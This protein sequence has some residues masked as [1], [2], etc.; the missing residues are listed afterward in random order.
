GRQRLGGV[1][2]FFPRKELESPRHRVGIHADCAKP[3]RTE[4]AG[5]RDLR[6]DAVAIGPG[7]ADDRDGVAT[8]FSNHVAEAVGEVRVEEFA[9]HGHGEP[10]G[11][12]FF[13]S[14]S[15]SSSTRLP[16]WV[17]RSRMTIHSCACL[18]RTRR[19]KSRRISPDLSWSH[20]IRA[21][22]S[23]SLPRMPKKIRPV[24]KSGAT[25]A[26]FTVIVTVS[27]WYLVCKY[28]P[29]SRWT[30]SAMRIVRLDMENADCRLRI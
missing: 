25:S 24:F 21:S 10:G 18:I 11:D 12:S 7:V 26:P 19:A 15:S 28:A 6:S 29:S 17:D 22:T 20:R 8:E 9:G 5:Q 27:P 16:R 3:E 13:S 1:E 14:S 2:G 4:G 30:S 23:S